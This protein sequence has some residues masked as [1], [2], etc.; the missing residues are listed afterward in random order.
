MNPFN[1]K[2]QIVAGIDVGSAM[3]KVVILEAKEIIAQAMSPTLADPRLAAKLAL[4][5]A[6]QEVNL[7]QNDLDFI[8]TT[9][10]GRRTVEFGNQVITEITANAKGVRFLGSPL[11]QV[12]TVI[13]L[14]AQDSKVIKLNENGEVTDFIMNEKCAAGTGRFLE[15]MARTLDIPL[16]DL[17][18]F[19]LKSKNPIKINA[20]CTVFAESEVIS[21]IAQRE[22]KEDILAGLHK[23]IAKRI[24]DLAKVITS[25][26]VV[27]L[28]VEELKILELK[29]R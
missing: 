20:T 9:G 13:D 14:G 15:V 16:E 1:E 27:F 23:V 21:L 22:K 4:E 11:G 3:T 2:S 7:S 28:M 17:G 25:K 24:V 19:S 29:K 6:L 26:E 8:V 10:Y 18:E 12:R 5:K